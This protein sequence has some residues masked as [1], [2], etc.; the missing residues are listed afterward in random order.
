MLQG[1]ISNN[2]VIH[3]MLKSD[4]IP[5]ENQILFFYQDC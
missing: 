1:L 4:C 3:Y 2:A 5:A